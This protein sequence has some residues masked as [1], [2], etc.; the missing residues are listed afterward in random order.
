[1]P[2]LDPE[3]LKQRFLARSASAHPDKSA[4][5]KK[6]AEAEFQHLNEAY[7]VLRHPRSRLLHLLD[8]AGLPPPSHAQAI[9]RAALELFEPIANVTRRAD[10]LLKEKAAAS[11]PM[12]KVQFFAKALDCVDEL[13]R[14]QTEARQRMSRIEEELRKKGASLDAPALQQ[15]AAAFGFF[16]RWRAQLE[17]RSTSLSF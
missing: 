1:L 13:Q 12:L 11:S 16:E 3:D 8:L 2:W 5:D 14:L 10:A 9:P 7:N 4:A 15:A 6:A 17:E